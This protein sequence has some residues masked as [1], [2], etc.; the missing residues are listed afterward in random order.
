MKPGVP[1]GT[2]IDETPSSVSAVTVT[3]L[4]MSVPELVMNVLAPS[5]TH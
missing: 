2:M 1:D 5:I 4:V 3:R